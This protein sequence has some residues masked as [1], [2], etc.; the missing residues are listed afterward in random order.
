MSRTNRLPSP[1]A[2]VEAY[3][4]PGETLHTSTF[5]A[6]LR[7]YPRLAVVVVR[8]SRRAKHGRYGRQDWEDSSI[9]TM[10]C[11]EAAGCRFNIEGLRNITACEGP[12]VFVG[13]H[14]STLETFS[15]PGIIDPVK[16]VT[17]VIKPSLMDYP[18][19]GH[20]MRSR[21]PIV[22]SRDNPRQDL[23]T[24]LEEGRRRLE[25][26]ISIVLFPQ[27]TRRLDFDP[28]Q[29]NSLGVK[30]AK[31]AGVPIIPVALKTDAWAN[32]R[33]VKEFGPIDPKKTIHLAF[34]SPIH[35]EGNG[36]AEHES[37]IAF[38]EKHLRQW[39]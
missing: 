15:L 30:L 16:P 29:F 4:T 14:M 26:G 35:I 19:F 36:R 39:R 20:V 1:L 21:N 17:F 2:S 31:S 33:I 22:V 3:K 32:G 24:V 27:T 18:L 28:A 12:A 13:N 7:F 6:T 34:G 11:L 10:L 38:I 9:A 23:V 25:E 37:V 8:A 5:L